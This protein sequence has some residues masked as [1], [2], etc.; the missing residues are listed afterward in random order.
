MKFIYI[1]FFMILNLYIFS[2]LTKKI[3]FSLNIKKVL[4]FFLIIFI[5]CHFMHVFDTTISNEVFTI[6]LLFS[7]S[8]FIFDFGRN[9]AIWVK[10]NLNKNEKDKLLIKWFNFWVNYVIYAMIFIFQIATLIEN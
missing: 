6:L 4:G 10:T 1:I 8:F 7:G 2:I 9:I 3:K 5:L